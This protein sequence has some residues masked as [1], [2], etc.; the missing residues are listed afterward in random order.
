MGAEVQ[1][2]SHLGEIDNCTDI[3]HF[4]FREGKSNSHLR[5]DCQKIGDLILNATVIM[6]QVSKFVLQIVFFIVIKVLNGV[7]PHAHTHICTHIHACACMHTIHILHIYTP[8]TSTHMHRYMH[9]QLQD[10]AVEPLNTF[11]L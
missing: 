2:S 4:I 1:S 11:Y 9:I 6:E 5:G 7:H 8:N 10:G 3:H